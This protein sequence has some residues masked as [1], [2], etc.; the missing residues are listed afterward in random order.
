[1]MQDCRSCNKGVIDKRCTYVLDDDHR[2]GGKRRLSKL[3][4]GE[5]VMIRLI[6]ATKCMF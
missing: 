5:L 6:C 1:M 4:R 3:A 2:D